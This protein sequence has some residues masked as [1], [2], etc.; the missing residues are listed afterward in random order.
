MV[1]KEGGRRITMLSSSSSLSRS[2]PSSCLDDHT[3]KTVSDLCTVYLDQYHD[4][5]TIVRSDCHDAFHRDCMASYF[6]K[7]RKTH[8]RV[9]V[10]DKTS[11]LK[12]KSKKTKTTMT[13]CNYRKSLQRLTEE[14]ESI[15]AAGTIAAAVAN[16]NTVV[17]VE[18]PNKVIGTT[19]STENGEG[20][21]E[22]IASATSSWKKT[23][24][25]SITSGGF[26]L[27][28]GVRRRD[29]GIARCA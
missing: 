1:I 21:E 2:K 27:G 4:E 20:D 19:T 9:R 6:M 7:K 3:E 12:A 13:S 24:K 26:T 15:T 8:T 11:F 23:T 5:D 29:S 18:T 22:P 10:A 25:T 17:T 14:R 16:D 28:R